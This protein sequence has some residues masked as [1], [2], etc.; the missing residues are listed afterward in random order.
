MQE[1]NTSIF[2]KAPPQTD[3][4]CFSPL[5]YVG[6]SHQHRMS[7][8]QCGHLQCVIIGT[9]GLQQRRGF[10]QSLDLF[11]WKETKSK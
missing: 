3:V 6:P 5:R 1:V 8:H 2:C 4:T 11:D 10:L 9:I 7:P